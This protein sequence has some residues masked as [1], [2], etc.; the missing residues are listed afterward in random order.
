MSPSEN[1]LNTVLKK[2]RRKR[3]RNSNTKNGLKPTS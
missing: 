2:R 3:K 1:L